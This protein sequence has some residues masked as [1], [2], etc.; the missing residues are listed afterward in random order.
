MLNHLPCYY[1]SW[2]QQVSRQMR[3]HQAVTLRRC[4]QRRALLQ[5][6][7]LF[8]QTTPVLER[9]CLPGLAPSTGWGHRSGW[10]NDPRSP[11]SEDPHKSTLHQPHSVLSRRSRNSCP[12]PSSAASC[13]PPTHRSPLQRTHRQTSAAWCL[14]KQTDQTLYSLREPQRAS[15]S[16]RAGPVDWD[17]QSCRHTG[18]YTQSLAFGWG[19]LQPQ[20]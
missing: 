9:C 4:S 11:C 20:L 2:L 1:S 7:Y 15:P 16:L 3:S 13:Q 18:C 6:Q 19:G 8:A 12:C 10:R 17:T 5:P 14:H